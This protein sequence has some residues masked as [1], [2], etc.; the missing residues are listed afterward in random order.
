MMN[1]K[2]KTGLV[3]MILAMVLSGFIGLFVFESGQDPYTVV[4]FRC[5][6][7]AVFLGLY[8]WWRGLLTAKT[9]LNKSMLYVLFG[10][11][12]LVANWIFL[13]TSFSYA[14]ISV[15]TVTYHFQPFFLLILNAV[16]FRERL[17]L[18]KA[19][20]MILAFI[21]L[22]LIVELDISQIS[23]SN[24]EF[25]GMLMALAAGFLYAVA[26][27]VVKKVKNLK[28]ELVAFVQI[29]MGVLYLW[30]F[31]EF[32]NLDINSYQWMHILALGFLNTFVM[33][34]IMYRAFAKLDVSII[35]VLVFIYPVVAIMV[36]YVF[37]AQ[38]LS[39]TQIGGIIL[40]LLAA[41]LVNV[42]DKILNRFTSQT[43]PTQLSDK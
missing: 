15:S 3:E 19:V 41:L 7:G 17:K 42:G 25:I 5:V 16:I 22:L 2:L 31:V 33:Y 30:P 26:T 4:F 6:L 13:F 27:L 28:S 18:G 37:Y 10:S 40:V 14:S 20:W 23:L 34:I 36:D 21:G 35:S 29:S 38:N 11:A 24:D 12:A 32:G 9:L 1:D 8:C 43:K 39:L